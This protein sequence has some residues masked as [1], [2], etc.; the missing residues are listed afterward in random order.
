MGEA[1]AR[2]CFC[3]KKSFENLRST[4]ICLLL[5]YCVCVLNMKLQSGQETVSKVN[6]NGLDDRCKGIAL[7]SAL[8]LS[9]LDLFIM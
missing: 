6:H 3:L 7:L 5:L 9:K 8:S 2:Q 4:F 1:Q